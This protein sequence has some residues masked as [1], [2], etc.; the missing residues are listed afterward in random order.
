MKTLILIFRTQMDAE[1]VHKAVDDLRNGK[2]VHDGLLRDRL[3]RTISGT[4]SNPEETLPGIPSHTPQENPALA[5]LRRLVIAW[6]EEPLNLTGDSGERLKAMNHAVKVISEATS[7][8][9]V[10]LR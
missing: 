5:A 6:S 4:L 2:G 1:K 3:S 7:T 8:P 10:Q 9:E